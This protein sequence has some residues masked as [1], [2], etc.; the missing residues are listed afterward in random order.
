MSNKCEW[1]FLCLLTFW[2]C[3]GN[4]LSL[5][6]CLSL[7]QR[8]LNYWCFSVSF[9]VRLLPAVPHPVMDPMVGPFFFHP[10]W[11]EG[12]ER[13]QVLT[14]GTCLF[15]DGGRGISGQ[16]TGRNGHYAGQDEVSP[17]LVYPQLIKPAELSSTYSR[18]PSLTTQLP[19]HSKSPP[20]TSIHLAW[21]PGATYP[22]PGLAWVPPVSVIS[23]DS[24]LFC[25]PQQGFLSY[26]CWDRK[27]HDA[28]PQVCV[29][30]T[31][32]GFLQ[33]QSYE[34]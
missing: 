14:L 22:V 3:S 1:L 29:Y 15:T 32:R 33:T 11:Q 18:K 6:P 30:L 27:D 12:A 21:S 28:G 34:N 7:G 25:L 17:I 23:C 4:R 5:F 19:C 9:S 13:D 24:F 20:L 2:V 26:M 31:L 10:L 16:R 8:F